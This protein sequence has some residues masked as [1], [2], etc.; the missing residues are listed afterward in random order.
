MSS[1]IFIITFTATVASIALSLFSFLS[2][3]KENSITFKKNELEQMPERGTTC[4]TIEQKDILNET[5]DVIGTALL[6]NNS[7]NFYIELTLPD[8]LSI[9]NCYL[10][11]S[12]NLYDFPVDS[13]YNLNW[14]NFNHIFQF[15]RLNNFNRIIIPLNEL[16]NR[17]YLAIAIEY[18]K[19]ENQKS[20]KNILWVDGIRFG[21]SIRGRITAYDKK[22][23][24]TQSFEGQ[25]E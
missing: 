2:C 24:L 8:S 25:N 1:K 11:S 17:S 23:C 4:G 9:L 13:N 21:S 18:G 22:S 5:N 10:H 3:E 6:F 20:I 16:P 14:N 7:K 15:T 12:L 19:Y